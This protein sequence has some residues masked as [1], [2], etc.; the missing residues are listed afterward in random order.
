MPSIGSAY[1]K[2]THSSKI[3]KLETRPREVH[4]NLPPERHWRK[5]SGHNPS[6]SEQRQEKA[7]QPVHLANT[8]YV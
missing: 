4:T 8:K 7:T 1:Q 3:S 5:G 2:D 6:N